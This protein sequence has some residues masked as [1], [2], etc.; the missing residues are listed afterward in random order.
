MVHH[1]TT[2]SVIWPPGLAGVSLKWCRVIIASWHVEDEIMNERTEQ[3]MNLEGGVTRRVITR[4][5]AAGGLAAL[6]AAV[7]AG[8]ALAHD[9]EDDADDS[10]DNVDT[11]DEV[12]EVDTV[13]TVGD[14]NSG[15]A[16][17]GGSRGKG[18]KSGKH[19]K[20]RH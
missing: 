8:R 18:K 4:G 16:P 19:G 14:D 20:G 12:D 1:W 15:V 7:G 11:V 3:T 17:T 5:A 13:D 9:G 6:F 2:S 10:V